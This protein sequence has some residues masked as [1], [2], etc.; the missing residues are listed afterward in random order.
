M[1]AKRK[2]FLLGISFGVIGIILGAFSA[3]GL[4]KVISAEAISTFETGVKYQIYHALFLVFLSS[5]NF[6]TERMNKIIFWM[7]LIGVIFFSGSIYGLATNSLSG[8]D[9]KIIAWITP[10]GGTLLIISWALVGIN[11]FKKKKN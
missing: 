9:F 7:I 4:E 8:F 1:K 10:I 11:V 5:Q 2:L 6:T 3:H